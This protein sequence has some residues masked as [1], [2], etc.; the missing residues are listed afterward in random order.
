MKYQSV[1]ERIDVDR[2]SEGIAVI[3]S[4][5]LEGDISRVATGVEKNREFMDCDKWISM[6]SDLGGDLNTLLDIE[7]YG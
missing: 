1:L 3:E 4:I 2:I 6:A 7:H 5:V